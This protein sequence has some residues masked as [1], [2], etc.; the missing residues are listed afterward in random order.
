[1]QCGGESKTDAPFR[2]QIV[3]TWATQPS[4]A[5][6]GALDVLPMTRLREA[7]TRALQRVGFM[8]E[9]GYGGTD[10]YNGR[11]WPAD[12]AWHLGS[13]ATELIEQLTASAEHGVTARLT[14][15]D[16]KRYYSGYEGDDR[17]QHNRKTSW[18]TDTS[19]DARR[20]TNWKILGAKNYLTEISASSARLGASGTVPITT[21]G[22]G[23]I[24]IYG[25]AYDRTSTRTR[26]DLAA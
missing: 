8:S 20:P 15:D 21:D 4:A 16:L 6:W 9:S 5:I 24:G 23:R 10:W 18:P 7:R 13:I 26:K 25:R 22:C 14:A 3:P 2:Q 1:M 11:E 12:L 19:N 17:L